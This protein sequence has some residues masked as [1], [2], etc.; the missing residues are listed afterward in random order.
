MSEIAE[1]EGNLAAVERELESLRAR[2][3][4][5]IAQYPD[6]WEVSPIVL[7]EMG[8]LEALRDDLKQQIALAKLQ[9]KK[10]S[11]MGV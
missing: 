1:L 10:H 5:I 6:S 7:K 4:I 8:R 9:Q 3:K 11:G 2:I